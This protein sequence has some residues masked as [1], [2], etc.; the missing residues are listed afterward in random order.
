M[1]KIIFYFTF[2][3]ILNALASAQSTYTVYSDEELNQMISN[4]DTITI[5]ADSSSQVSFDFFAY[6]KNNTNADLNVHIE[7]QPIYI[8]PDNMLQLCYG[9]T[10]FTTLYCDG[11]IPATSPGE[12]HITLYYTSSDTQVNIVKAMIYN[13]TKGDTS[14]FFVKFKSKNTTSFYNPQMQSFKISKPFPNPAN[15]FVKFRYSN[16]NSNNA[17]ITIYSILGDP[18]TSKK[19]SNNNGIL[20]INTSNLK[21]GY[22]IYTVSVNDKKIITNRFLVKH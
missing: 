17:N 4:N 7:L 13:N 19:I 16:F 6:L 1:K 20:N 21:T 10:C 9:G 22:Y 15:E 18:I 14:T 11:V 12:L 8:S 5:I 2:I 3:F